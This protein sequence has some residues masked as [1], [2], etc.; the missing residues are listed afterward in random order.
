MIDQSVRE[1]YMVLNVSHTFIKHLL[2]DSVLYAEK[3]LNNYK[4]VYIIQIA[5]KIAGRNHNLR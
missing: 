5:I 2:S 1:I 4:Y 3:K